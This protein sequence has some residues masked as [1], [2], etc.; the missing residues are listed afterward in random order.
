M[1][2]Q[3]NKPIPISIST[4]GGQQTWLRRDWEVNNL[5]ISLLLEGSSSHRDNTSWRC[6]KSIL[7]PRDCCKTLT[8][9]NFSPHD[10]SAVT[11]LRKSIWDCWELNCSSAEFPCHLK[12]WWKSLGKWMPA[13]EFISFDMTQLACCHG[14]HISI[15]HTLTHKQLET[16]GFV[17]STVATE[18][19]VLKHQA[20]S[21]HSSDQILIALEQ[22]HT[23]ILHL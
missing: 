11:C 6:F 10:T 13:W 18:A 1:N 5:L 4:G 16:L 20:I 15:P 21:I 3:I 2:G 23:E 12:C 17:L 9:Q 22:F 7:L 14:Y 8:W 19:L